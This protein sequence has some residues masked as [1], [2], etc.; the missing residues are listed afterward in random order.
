M[1]QLGFLGVL[2][3]VLTGTFCAVGMITF[4]IRTNRKSV[5]TA[6]TLM[7]GAEDTITFL[8]DDE[9]LVDA[10]PLARSLL[11]HRGAN[12]T[13][14]EAFLSLLSARFPELRSQLSDLADIGKKAIRPVDDH[15]SWLEAEY[16]N[17]LARIKLVQHEDHPDDTIDPLT[18]NAIEN[19]LETLRSIGEASPQL[20]WKQDT[21]GVMTWANKSYIELSEFLF[22]VASDAALPWP[23]RAVFDNVARPSGH[24]PVIDMHCVNPDPQEKPIWFEV[25]SLRRGSETIHFAVDATAVVSAKDAQ[26][27]FVQTLTKT[28]AHL[29]VGLA[30]FD[31]DRRLVLFN[32]ALGDLSHLPADFLIARP[33]LFSFLDRLRDNR[34]MPEP[35]NYSSWRNHM[36]ALESAAAQG[37]YQETWAVPNGQT[38]RVTG[39]PHPNGAIAFLLEDIS[40]EVSLTRKFRSQI[41]LG[42]AVINNL[43]AAVCVFSPSG[44]M[45]MANTAYRSLWGTEMEGVI[46]SRDFSEESANWQEATAPSPVW[47]KLHDAISLGRTEASWCGSVWLDSHIEISCQYNPLP[48]GNHQVTFTLAEKVDSASRVVET[49][50]FEP[51]RSLSV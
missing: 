33:T 17:G 25:T 35:K 42:Y 32:P 48:D 5:A 21:Q 31:A 27:D 47:V 18:A 26:R 4:W 44:I 15:Q 50:E 20:I 28:F 38:F 34:M 30:I 6:R 9:I 24:A 16:W 37:S 3:A 10:S 23:P 43:E 51:Q 41:D 12:Q 2:G 40:D 46:N 39:K 14:W 19:E 13:H 45:V 1:A 7:L 49:P 36:A 8:F 11:E 22:P 29:S